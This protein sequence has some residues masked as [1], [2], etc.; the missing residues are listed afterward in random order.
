MDKIVRAGNLMRKGFACLDEY[1]Y[2]NALKI[3]RKLK[4]LR[5]SSAFEILALAYWRLD[6]LPMAIKVLEEGVTKAGHVWILWELLGNCYSDAGIFAKSERAYQKALKLETCDQDV[7]HLNR[8]IAF[9]R[10]GKH[11]EAKSA[12]ELVQSPQ[13]RRQRD[14]CRIRTALALGDVRFARRLALPLSKCRLTRT[15]TFDRKSESEILLSCALALKCHPDTKGR[16]LRLAY[17]AADEQPN[18]AEALAL[19]REIQL[20]K[21]SC[22]VLF[23]LLVHGVWSGTIGNSSVPPGFFRTL[24]VAAASQSAALRDAKRFF[25]MSVRKSL[26]IEEAI[27]RDGSSLSLTGVYYLSGYAFYPRRRKKRNSPSPKSPWRCCCW[28]RANAARRPVAAE[29]TRLIFPWEKARACQRTA[30]SGLVA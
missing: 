17:L 9:N 26:A 19:I 30:Q 6:K 13:L 23:R 2:A 25:P 10:A 16:A 5:H 8:A 4:R 28:A 14:A 24:E 22:L 20:R 18:N 3:G 27:R 12:L 1:R 7:V 15:D 21:A 11:A 29:L